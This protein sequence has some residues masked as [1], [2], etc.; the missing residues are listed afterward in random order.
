[1]RFAPP[2]LAAFGL[3]FLPACG[4]GFGGSS[5]SQNPSVVV[6][7]TTSGQ[8]NDFAV[9]PGGT[10]PLGVAAIAYTGSGALDEIVP[11]VT[12]TWAARYVNPLTDPPSVATYTAG[13]DPN[14]FKT[15]PPVPTITPPVPILVQFGTGAPSTAYAGYRVL[16]ANVTANHVFIGSVPAVPAPYCLAIVATSVPGN[17]AGAH[18]V[19][20]SAGP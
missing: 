11:G 8:A 17:V 6:L 5:A 12:Y 16:G 14:G 3:A 13:P 18:T 9:A 10:S 4:S 19:I 2:L 7:S 20:V 1:M 15:C